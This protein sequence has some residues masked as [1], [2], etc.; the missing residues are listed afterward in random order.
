MIPRRSGRIINIASIA[1][2]DYAGTSNAAYAA[3]KGAVI[4]LTRTASQQLAK[5]DINV[6]ALPGVARTELSDANLQ[7]RAEQAGVS[8]E[9][10][11]K[12]RDEAIPLGRPCEPWDIAAMAVFLASPGARNITGQSYNVDGGIIPE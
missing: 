4:S 5:H 8:I 9:I 2:R 11:E 3:N 7:V 10:M 12:R 6:Y 1:G